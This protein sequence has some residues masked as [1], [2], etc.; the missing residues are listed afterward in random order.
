MK[1]IKTIS[2]NFSERPENTEIDSIV[3]HYT[4][5]NNFQDALERMCNPKF[6]VSAH[7]AIDYNGDIHQLVEDSNKAWHSG[8]SHW[9]GKKN[10]NEN[11]IG[12]EIANLGHEFGYEEFTNSQVESTIFLCKK[13]K[14]KYNIPSQNIIGH[15]DVA[16]DRKEDPGEFFP[17][18]SFSKLGLGIYHNFITSDSEYTGSCYNLGDK[19]S[20]IEKIQKSL[21]K[22][23][24]GILV[25]GIYDDQTKSVIT[26]FYRRFF[27]ERIKTQTDTRYPS[28]IKW[29]D[30]AT[31]IVSE[32]LEQL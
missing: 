17:W 8:I 14:S 15:S 5:M 2:P 7:Y 28:E 23:G 20:E 24:Y 18:K 3:L 22:I 9:N 27:P 6:E 13:L 10:I 4:G 31:K 25:N 21:S 12:I 32:L 16:P 29:D 1:I 19:G 30:K 11:S 26:S